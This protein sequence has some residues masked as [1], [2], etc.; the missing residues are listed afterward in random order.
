MVIAEGRSS[1]VANVDLS[2]RSSVRQ[3]QQNGSGNNR[4]QVQDLVLHRR[5]SRDVMNVFQMLPKGLVPP[6]G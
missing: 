3:D 2:S 4:I 1:L 5:H 6:S